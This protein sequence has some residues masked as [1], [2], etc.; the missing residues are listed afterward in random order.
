MS[1]RSMQSIMRLQKNLKLFYKD[2][3]LIAR[4]RLSPLVQR[5]AGDRGGDGGV[6]AAAVGWD[7]A[8]SGGAGGGC[9]EGGL[10]HS[11]SPGVFV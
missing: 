6:P 8:R 10:I 4:I 7:A 1:C 3:C 2:D 9:E 11:P 5:A